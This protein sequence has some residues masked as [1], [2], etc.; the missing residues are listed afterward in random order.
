MVGAL[1][2]YA[3]YVVWRRRVLDE[4]AHQLPRLALPRHARRDRRLHLPRP[5][6]RDHR[7]VGI[8]LAGRAGGSR[9]PSPRRLGAGLQ[10]SRA[11]LAPD[12]L[13]DHAPHPDRAVRRCRPRRPVPRRPHL[14]ER[15]VAGHPRRKAGRGRAADLH[16][17]G[18][19]RLDV[20]ERLSRGAGEVPAGDPDRRR[21]RRQPRRV[22][23]RHDPRRAARRDARLSRLLPRRRTVDLR[24]VGRLGR[25]PRHHACPHRADRR[26][27]RGEAPLRRGE[28][29]HH[30]VQPPRSDAELARLP[31][32]ARFG[33]LSFAH[34]PRG[35]L[36]RHARPRRLGRRRRRGGRPRRPPRAGNRAALQRRPRRRAHA[37][38]RPRGSPGSLPSLRLPAGAGAGPLAAAAPAQRDLGR[39][40]PADHR[41]RP[42]YRRRVPGSGPLLRALP[43]LLQR[44]RGAGVGRTAARRSRTRAPAASRPASPTPTTSASRPRW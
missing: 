18:D 11:A 9:A 24:D 29:R 19:R 15:G 36:P 25:R 16:R 40:R 2:V 30:R 31:A 17:H 14:P 43:A 42:L 28:Q 8:R 44:L 35:D 37:L 26:A 23:H 38:R 1:P 32:A 10:L 13:A 6:R 12:R 20:G 27:S 3:A 21:G 4:R 39:Q 5:F 33:R 34:G 7:P 22:L 41:L